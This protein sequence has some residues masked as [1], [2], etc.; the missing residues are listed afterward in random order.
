MF[1][2]I[3]LYQ[4]L[5]W[6]EIDFLE[7]HPRVIKNPFS[8]KSGLK[9][10]L[11]PS[12]WLHYAL[13]DLYEKFARWFPPTQTPTQEFKSGISLFSSQGM[14][15]TL[16]SLRMIFK[17]LQFELFGLKFHFLGSKFRKIPEFNLIMSFT[18]NQRSSSKQQF[19][20]QRFYQLKWKLSRIELN[21]LI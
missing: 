6:W 1:H 11:T 18:A 4:W 20:N 2:D 12:F 21:W 16:V 3:F 8:G 5:G 7:R 17:A 10:W 19:E 13:F 14:D 9:I 15:S